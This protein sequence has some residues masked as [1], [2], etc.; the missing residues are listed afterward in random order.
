MLCLS[1]TLGRRGGRGEGEEKG[2]GKGGEEEI[3]KGEREVRKD[4]GR[5]EK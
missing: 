1:H 4:G 2:R 5:R 3:W